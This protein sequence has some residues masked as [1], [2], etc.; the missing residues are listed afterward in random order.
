MPHG[1]EVV[2]GRDD[3]TRRA[4]QG[5]VDDADVDKARL[6]EARV[7]VRVAPGDAGLRV[8]AGRAQ[9]QGHEDPS[10]QLHSERVAGRLLDDQAEQ[11]VAGIGVRPSGAGPEQRLVGRRNR[12]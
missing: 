3:R 12:D 4:E 6:A 11:D 7:P 1:R 2:C 8:E 9:A 5:G 10:S